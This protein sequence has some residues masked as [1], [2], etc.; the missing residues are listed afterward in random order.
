MVEYILGV[1]QVLGSIPSASVRGEKKV[2]ACICELVRSRLG[3]SKQK[4]Q[5]P[6]SEKR[7]S[8]AQCSAGG[9]TE[10]AADSTCQGLSSLAT[11]SRQA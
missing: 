5:D 9:W 11:D 4:E 1:L 7:S 6:S 2:T 8:R 10:C 3:R